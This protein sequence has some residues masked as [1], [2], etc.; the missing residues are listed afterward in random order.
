M[1]SIQNTLPF[2]AAGAEL[3]TREVFMAQRLKDHGCDVFAGSSDTATRKLCFR[4]VITERGL[5]FVIIGKDSSGKCLTYAQ[6]FER[7]YDEPLHTKTK[8]K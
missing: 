4:R 2:N 6:A 5:E 3:L 1:S 8:G 7:T